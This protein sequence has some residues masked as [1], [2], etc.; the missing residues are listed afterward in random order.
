MA[1]NGGDGGDDDASV[2]LHDVALGD[3]SDSIRRGD[4]DE[5]DGDDDD[6]EDF[7][8][9]TMGLDIDDEEDEEN[10][11]DEDDGHDAS[12]VDES[13]AIDVD[14]TEVD[15]EM[16][17][18][19]TRTKLSLV[20][21]ALDTLES[22][23]P[24]DPVESLL[25]DQKDDEYQRFLA[26]LLP[27]MDDHLSFLDEE[28]E[29]YHPDEDDDDDEDYDEE[30]R[31]NRTLS[32]PL[33]MVNEE[34]SVR[35]SKKELTALLWDSTMLK[36]PP[37][38]THPSESMTSMPTG[39]T[40]RGARPRTELPPSQTSVKSSHKSNAEEA[41]FTDEED[42]RAVLQNLQGKVDQAQC[43][44]L[45]SQMHKHMQLLLQTFHLL[46]NHPDKDTE[47]LV[48]QRKECE[49]M[50]RELQVR[51]KR[52]LQHKGRLLAKLNPSVTA[53]SSEEAL[54]QRRV[55]RSLSAAHAAVAHPSM[56]DIVGSQSMDALTTKFRNG[57]T[58]TDR[59]RVLQESMAEVDK[60]VLLGRKKRRRLAPRKKIA[61]NPFS[62]IEDR[63]LFHGVKRF[64]A[65]PESWK[66]IHEHL[67]P[68]KQ[69]D[70]LRK[71]YRYL[72]S[73][74]KKAG[75]TEIK[76]YH[77]TFNSRKFVQFALEEDVRL[78]RGMVEYMNDKRRYSRVARKYLPHRH[79]LEIR[80]RWGR[81]KKVELNLL[82][83]EHKENEEGEGHGVGEREGEGTGE[84]EGDAEG[85]ALPPSF[86]L[87]LK[88]RLEAQLRE[89][90]KR[91]QTQTKPT[92][93]EVKAKIKAKIKVEE[94][95]HDD[96]QDNGSACSCRTKN[97][98]PALFFSSWAVI[99]PQTLLQRTCEHNWPAFIEDQRNAP[100]TKD[101]MDMVSRHAVS[102]AEE[103]QQRQHAGLSVI[104]EGDEEDE[105]AQT[106]QSVEFEDEDDEESEFERD[107]LLSSDE[108][109]SDSEYEQMELTD[110][111]DSVELMNEMLAEEDDDAFEDSEHDST[112]VSTP[113]REVQHTLRLENLKTPGDERTQRALQALERRITGKRASDR[114]WHFAVSTPSHSFTELDLFADEVLGSSGD[115]GGFE[116]DELRGSS[117]EDSEHDTATE[118]DE[119][120]AFP[121]RF[122]QPL[123]R[124]KL[125]RCP[126]CDHSPCVCARMERLLHR[127]GSE[128]SSGI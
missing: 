32:S 62:A 105:G 31:G 38:F 7:E 35:V 76:E 42:D 102:H 103:E 2:R 29:E 40:P 60:H 99:S 58:I 127:M 65:D 3:E 18:H 104:E 94:P 86:Y 121:S 111:D 12:S 63:L 90:L 118:E 51:G 79:R 22:F 16:I 43:I 48:K 89:Q 109:D 21:V 57:C 41:V 119:E 112:P 11:L 66:D 23:L 25:G 110:D 9:D 73:A 5:A 6:D 36:V 81:L 87:G 116:R 4:A 46:A 74:K 19:R 59:N 54:E 84:G 8:L 85:E 117:D 20:D 97:L 33:A 45:A 64:G 15:S 108:G 96:L 28:D 34:Q 122:V 83:E 61:S 26:S 92:A 67:L 53:D 75:A 82:A 71:R 27:T 1:R 10:E 125:V 17:A 106:Q 124:I 91:Q 77:H 123:K 115:E 39:S 14:V 44:H 13:S 47:R 100:A 68:A 69:P 113:S 126:T 78:A 49:R 95:A 98:H 70:M 55:T 37:T 56:F 72:T 24:P 107:E 50:L 120:D 101:T 52:A 128:S 80:K 114:D 30:D 93:V 88:E